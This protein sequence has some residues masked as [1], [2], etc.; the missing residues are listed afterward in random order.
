MYRGLILSD[1]FCE[2]EALDWLCYFGCYT[3]VIPKQGSWVSLKFTKK[4]PIR[5]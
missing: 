2:F 1:M 3:I 4:Q 5:M